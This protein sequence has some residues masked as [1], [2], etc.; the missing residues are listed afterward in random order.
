MKPFFSIVIPTYNRANRLMVAIDSVLNQ[1]FEDFELLVVDDGSTDDTA[2]QVKERSLKNPRLKYI[3]QEN[4]ER[5]A[6]RNKGVSHAVGDYVMFLDSDDEFLPDCLQILFD[7]INASPEMPALIAGKIYIKDETGKRVALNNFVG[8]Q[9]WDYRKFL[10][11]NPVAC[12]FA[13][14]RSFDIKLFEESRA[15]VTMEDWIFLLINTRKHKMLLIDRPLVQMHDHDQR[16]M[17]NNQ[18]VIDRRL[19]ATKWLVERDYFQDK[20]DV[21]KLWS[22]TYSFCAIHEYLD[23]NNKKSRFYIRKAISLDGLKSKYIVA[24]LKSILGRAWIQRMKK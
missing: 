4:A 19:E 11:G 17:A 20:E 1:T 15:L 7:E 24:Y 2:S 13:F 6:A 9:T 23:G 22:G 18:L 8:N 21:K 5:G 10:S 14:R 16:S 3:F 12:N